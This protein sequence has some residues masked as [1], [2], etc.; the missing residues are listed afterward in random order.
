MSFVNIY[1]K[2]ALPILFLYLVSSAF[3][4]ETAALT[5]GVDKPHI[6][7]IAQAGSTNSGI[8]TFRNKGAVPVTVQVGI[9]DWIFDRDG[10]M[11]FK[12]PGTTPFSCANWID[13]VPRRTVIPPG[14]L[15]EFN[16]N[17]KIPEDATGGH[18][19]VI[20][21]ESS[22][23]EEKKFEGMGVKLVGRIGTV[24]Y[25]ETEGRVNKMGSIPAFEVSKPEGNK[26]LVLKYKFRNE[27]NAYIKFK[28][29][30][31]I[32]D[33]QGTVY[34][35]AESQKKQGTLPG[36]IRE[37]AIKWF[38]SLPKGIY[39]VILTIDMGED[40]PPLVKEASIRIEE[41]IL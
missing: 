28:G 40:V 16:Y 23:S 35:M 26:P 25:Q 20:F 10:K 39:N 41:D 7:V 27:G 8:I 13:I 11:Q 9:E 3:V 5:V 34:G 15:G 32:F 6:D 17:I 19:A 31:N 33:E 38:G 37:D 14:E 2:T 12:K 4:Y 29:I 1:K 22:V 36:D 18:Y 30:L 21:F 24:V